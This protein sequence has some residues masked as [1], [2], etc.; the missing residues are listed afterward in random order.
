MVDMESAAIMKHIRTVTDDKKHT[1]HSLRHNMKD[2]LISA[3]ASQQDQDAIL[4]HSSGKIGIRQR[5]GAANGNDWG[6]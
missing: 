1:I 2:R 3:G 5:Q 4:G 6:A